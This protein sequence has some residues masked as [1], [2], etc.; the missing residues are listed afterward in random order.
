MPKHPA[1]ALRQEFPAVRVSSPGPLAG[2]FA[3]QQ[4]AKQQKNNYHSSSLRTMNVNQTSL[5]PHGVE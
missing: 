5:H 2:D 4:I 3:R 1:D